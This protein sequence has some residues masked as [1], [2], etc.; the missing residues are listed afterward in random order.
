MIYS[1]FPYKMTVLSIGIRMPEDLLSRSEK[2]SRGWIIQR[3]GNQKYMCTWP[4]MSAS[5]IIFGISPRVPASTSLFYIYNPYVWH[6]KLLNVYGVELIPCIRWIIQYFI[7]DWLSNP[8]TW[9]VLSFVLS[10][11]TFNVDVE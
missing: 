6:W 2:T 1:S 9:P 4:K 3:F 10:T 7:V 8:P 5:R 11:Y